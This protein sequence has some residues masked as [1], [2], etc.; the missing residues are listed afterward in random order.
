MKRF[1]SMLLHFSA[2]LVCVFSVFV[3]SSFFI[4]CVGANWSV[5]WPTFKT[6]PMAN[7]SIA[8]VETSD[9]FTLMRA[10]WFS[11]KFGIPENE[12][13]AY[14][15]KTA[16]SIVKVTLK[17]FYPNLEF[18]PAK[19]G[20]TFPEESIQLDRTI[21]FKG[22]LPE[23]G[24]LVKVEGKAP[25]FLLLIHEITL[26]TD[27]DKNAFFDYALK[28]NEMD[29][30]KPVENISVILTFT[31]WDNIRQRP[32]YSAVLEEHIPVKI[33]PKAGDVETILTS[34]ISKIP[35]EIAK[36]AK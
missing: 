26:G 20:K 9:V 21:S 33:A 7:A 35:F 36:G 3:F 16:D 18:L 34:I 1:A 27:L 10:K 11:N 31:L 2:S 5:S 25:D 29:L 15:G 28:Q 17:N 13:Y 22:R 32:L 8:L 12:S 4:A 24:S 19:T 6:P 30:H 14:Y 23:Q